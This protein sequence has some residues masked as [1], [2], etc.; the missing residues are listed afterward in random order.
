MR[1]DWVSPTV[2]GVP[3][4]IVFSDDLSYRAIGLMSYLLT[5]RADEPPTLR[6]LVESSVEG[7]DAIVT[8]LGDLA[9]A[10]LVEPL[11]QKPRIPSD[12]RLRVL[13]RDGFTCVGCGIDRDLAAD[14]VIPESHGGATTFDN[15][16]TLCRSCNSA[17]GDS[18]PDL[19]D[20][21]PSF[22]SSH[23]PGSYEWGVEV[24]RWAY[25]N[26]RRLALQMAPYADAI[27]MHGDGG[28]GGV[29]EYIRKVF[30]EAGLSVEQ[31]ETVSSGPKRQGISA[32]K[33]KRIHERDVYRC[34][35]CGSHKDLQIDHVI[36]VARGGSNEDENLQTLCNLCNGSKGARSSADYRVVGLV[37]Q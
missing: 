1:T 34:L 28:G 37:D 12:L 25:A 19:E 31:P 11:Y 21:T 8:A 33:R 24:E 9:E 15:L 17:K 2:T 36:P 7:R 23:R 10:G 20:D 27:W 13:R 30:G 4:A 5:F 14:H 18:L 16:Q 35:R 29:L 6:D 32:A 22:Y 3:D 26:V